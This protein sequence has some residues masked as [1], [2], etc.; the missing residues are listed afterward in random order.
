MDVIK[1]SGHT[2]LCWPFYR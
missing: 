2:R 1:L